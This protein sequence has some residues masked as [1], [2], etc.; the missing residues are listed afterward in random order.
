MFNYRKLPVIG[1][2]GV[3]L[4]HV[5][6]WILVLG[7]EQNFIPNMWHVVFANVSVESRFVDTCLDGLPNGSGKVVA[8]PVYSVG[9][10][11]LL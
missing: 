5:G 4:A 10:L 6:S 8:L 9:S 11:L 1:G 7:G 2:T 3:V